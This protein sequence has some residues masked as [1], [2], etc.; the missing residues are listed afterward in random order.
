[1]PRFPRKPRGQRRKL[2]RDSE[3]GPEDFYNPEWD[4]LQDRFKLL[5]DKFVRE[6]IKDFN[7]ANAMRRLGY[8][9]SAVSVHASKFLAHPYTQW[10]LRKMMEELD[11]KSIIT[12]NLVLMGLVREA[13]YHGVES[14]HSA[15]VSALKS[16]ARILGMEVIK[17]DG[18]MKIKGGLLAVPL[19]KSVKDWETLSRQAQSELKREVRK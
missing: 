11:E 6:Y 13:N 17:V 8:K 18:D 2:T 4:D 3:P 9:H 1:M 5:R 15:R 14:T 10:R 19:V 7:G 12:R 16:M